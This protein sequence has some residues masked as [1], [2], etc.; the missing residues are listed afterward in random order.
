[1]TYNQLSYHKFQTPNLCLHYDPQDV[2]EKKEAAGAT[3]N[4]L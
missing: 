1:M 2:I 3:L 4:L